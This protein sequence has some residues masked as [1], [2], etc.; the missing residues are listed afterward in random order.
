MLVRTHAR[1]LLSFGLVL[2]LAISCSDDSSSGDDD[3]DNPT[4]GTT[5]TP[6]VPTGTVTS[7]PGFSNQSATTSPTTNQTATSSTGTTGSGGNAGAGG[8]GECDPDPNSGLP[9]GSEGGAAGGAG[10]P[11]VSYDDGFHFTDPES[12]VDWRLKPV[13]ECAEC[14]PDATLEA[15][16][17][18]M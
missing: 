18:T 16:C 17:G 7:N 15:G 14:I 2:G 4:S 13:A 1:T 5:G 6:I 10:A 12:V 3:D 8:S 9:T 11:S